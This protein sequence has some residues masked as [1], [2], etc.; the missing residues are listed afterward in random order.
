MVNLHSPLSLYSTSVGAKKDFELPW[1][2][3]VQYVLDVTA[4]AYSKMRQEAQLR[5]NYD[6]EVLSL[7][8]AENYIEAVANSKPQLL[9][10]RVMREVP[11]SKPDMKYGDDPTPIRKSPRIDIQI[12][13]SWDKEYR[14][15]YFAWECKKI[16]D[17]ATNSSLITNYVSE[18]VFRYCDSD[19][20]SEI[21]DAGML[22]YVVAGDIAQIV[23]GINDSM[24]S[25]RRERI[26]PKSEILVSGTP[27]G[28]VEHVYESVHHRANSSSDI[29]LYHWFLIFDWIDMQEDTAIGA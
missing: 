20:S 9:Q 15:R 3:F 18:G 29:H 24:I 23:D 8:L 10:L 27:V 28:P 4:E 17:R 7:I 1:S 22:G 16:A 5:S 19:Y 11:V 25:P 6:E 13:G 21:N 14:R 12:Y 2:V 26:L